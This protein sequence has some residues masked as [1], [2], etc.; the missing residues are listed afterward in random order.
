MKEEIL[1][2]R[3]LGMSIG[4]ISEVTGYSVTEVSTVIYNQNNKDKLKDM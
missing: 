3:K 2:L 1:A 4:E